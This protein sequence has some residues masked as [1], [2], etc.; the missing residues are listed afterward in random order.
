M[1]EIALRYLR[2]KSRSPWVVG[3]LGMMA[4]A[5]AF[6]SAGSGGESRFDFGYLVILILGAACVSR[7]V[8][9]GSLQMILCRPVRR[10]DYLLGRYAGIL[11]AYGIV[12][13]ASGGLALVLSAGLLPVLGVAP[14]PI[15]L[16]RLATAVAASFL[17][18]AGMAATILFLATFL[19]GYGDILGF[20]LLT[21]L[22]AL[23]DLASRIL[24]APWLHTAGNIL[25]ENVLPA[26]DWTA[27]LR[28]EQPVGEACGRWVLA[29]VAYLVLAVVVFSRREFA[30]G[31]D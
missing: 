9:S 6:Q 28:G 14:Q 13:V 21:P 16:P 1:I 29:S 31:H 17:T 5:G 25:R 12:L 30:Y 22:A 24:N 10:S 3:A 19:P 4:L 23:P 27:V 15:D 8:A 26:V 2:Q 18:G 7:D 20:V 11:F